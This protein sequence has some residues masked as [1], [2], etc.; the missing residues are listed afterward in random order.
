[1]GTKRILGSLSF[2]ILLAFTPVHIY[3][4]EAPKVRG[5]SKDK[6]KVG[7]Y[8]PLAG[9][10]AASAKDVVNGAQAYFTHVN[11]QG[12]VNGRKV[13]YLTENDNY[14]PQQAV[15][16]ARKLVERDQIFAMVSPMGSA[17]GM[18]VRRYLI[19]QK[20]PLVG[21]ISPVP[22]LAEPKESLIFGMMPVSA[23]SAHATVDWALEALK[24]KRVAIFFQ[25]DLFGKESKDVT[26]QDL[27][28]AGVDVV[29]VEGYLV[30]DTDVS[31][32]VLKIK[33]TNPD[34]VFFWSLPKH[35]AMFLKEAQKQGWKVNW[36]G[37]SMVA[38]PETGRLAGDAVNGLK[39]VI[40]TAL[41][42]STDPL[43]VEKVQI[44]KKYA[45]ETK[46]GYYSF[47]GMLGAML[48]TEGL[49]N[50]GPNP[51]T[52]S[53]I[54]GMEIIKDFKTGLVSPI[55]YSPGQHWRPPRYATAEWRAGN[56]VMIK[57]W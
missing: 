25:N 36:V 13:E 48:F 29:A 50:T 55:T 11:D 9:I 54:K 3:G 16:V 21:P 31:A 40:Y 5:I 22:E 19:Q 44:I 45:P 6:V 57:S 53:F 41:P 42:E 35:T 8:Q 24:P 15:A 26:E 28:K 52:E 33:A 14:E 10:L 1:M 43:M 39:M 56:M 20:V 47:I 18:A 7:A 38:D 37:P 17:T 23:R 49:K 12:G 4:A 46:L 34:T 30:T 51:T 32:T 2:L 27:K